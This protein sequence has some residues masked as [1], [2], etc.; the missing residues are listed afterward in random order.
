PRPMKP[1]V[2]AADE[3]VRPAERLAVMISS[4]SLDLPHHRATATEAVLRAGFFPLAM[5]HGTAE[6]SSDALSFSLRMVDQADLYIGIIAYRYGYV[7]DDAAA[8][9]NGWSVTEHEYRRAL[10]RG[11]PVLIF[12]M[13][14]EHPVTRK[15]FELSEQAQR[16][17]NA[18]KAELQQK[19]I[20]GFF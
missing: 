15:D 8:N 5:E 17:L 4:T 13:H 7:P 10:E 9:P 18:F 14:E 1:P 20:C 2:S 3:T 19:H 11:I 16:K 6:A 12:L